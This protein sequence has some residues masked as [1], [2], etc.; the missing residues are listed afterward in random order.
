MRVKEKNRRSSQAVTC[1]SAEASRRFYSWEI[2]TYRE[3]E[4][5]GATSRDRHRQTDI[6]RIEV[7][8]LMELKE[9]AEKLRSSINHVIYSD[10]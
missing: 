10:Y 5:Q 7:S 1:D 2:F 8:S 4:R 3:G 9:A 6:Q